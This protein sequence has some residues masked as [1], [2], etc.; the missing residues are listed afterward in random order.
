MNKPGQIIGYRK[1]GAPIRLI[2][3]GSGESDPTDGAQND[4]AGSDPE[5]GAESTGDPEGDPNALGDAGKK[6]LD[7]MKAKW[8]SER[9]ARKQ[10][11]TQLAERDAPKPE[12]DAPDVDAIKRQA[13]ADATRKANERILKAEIRAQ[14][15]GK[16]S[17]PADAL[18]FIDLTDFEA[19]GEGNFNANEIESAISDLLEAK[20][21]LSAQGGRRFQG[22]ADG[23]AR[24]GSDGPAQLTRA[25][26]ERMSPEDIIKAQNEGRLTDLGYKPIK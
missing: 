1:N 6:A 7:A 20:P 21:Y 8:R 3:G 11:E 14:A 12:G 24:K 22:S 25:E 10:L 4:P 26:V 5:P 16:L 15:A 17:D 13:E 19:D 23:G 18:R 9:D 2:A